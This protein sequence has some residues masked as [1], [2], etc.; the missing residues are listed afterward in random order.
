MIGQKAALVVANMVLGTLLGLIATILVGRFM[1]PS[2]VGQMAFAV[3]LL[4]LLFFVTD[5]GMGQA[6]VKRV[7]E[8][9][10]PGDCFATYAVF[11]LVATTFF[12]LLVGG[13]VFLY[14]GILHKPLEDT[15]LPI[16][17]VI[18]GY[19]VAKAL[20]DIGQ[21]SF[22]ARLEVA[23][24]QLAQLIDTIIRVVLTAFFALIVASQVHKLA[25]L[26]GRIPAASAFGWVA[27]DPGFALAVATAVGAVAAAAVSLTLL[28]RTLEWGRFRSDLLKD[29]ASFALPLFVSNSI[30]LIAVYVDGATL[31]FFRGDEDVGIFSQVRRLPLVLAGLGTA[32]AA[33]LFPAI[34]SMVARGDQA[35][36]QRTTDGALRYLSLL[37]VPTAA[38]TVLFAT[39]ILHLTIG[40]KWLAGAPAL[41]LLSIGVVVTSFG[42]AHA[43]LLLGHGRSGLVARVGIA[44]ALVVVILN[45]VLVPDDIRALGL[46]LAGLG[47]TGA[48]IATLA[49]GLVWYL[50]LRATTQRV[51]D[52]RE[53]AHIW[54]HLAGALVMLAALY[55]LD[56]TLVP[57]ARWYHLLVYAAVGGAVYV[58]TLIALRELTR[59]DAQFIQKV[60]HPGD[61]ARY[62]TGE[63][64]K[65]RE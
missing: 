21:S 31:G 14:H 48:A 4:G 45:L 43:Y 11:K 3:N 56:S 42:H 25:P 46:P 49:S 51:V 12:V 60:L 39:D 32:L 61:M 38:F 10:D 19:Y 65:K 47:V 54:R 13:G 58:A 28:F 53:R 20:A 64:R 17:L 9:R 63:I 5:L 41:A 15:T 24:S 37:L 40:D 34:S 57:L 22:D 1:A 55:A 44:S 35:G 29:Y 27:R 2:E 33:I 18:L 59:E 26:A 50:G 23:K 6:H 7:S 36:V 62:I 16:I 30:V 52:Y 8:G